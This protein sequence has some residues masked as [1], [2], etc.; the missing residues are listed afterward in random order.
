MPVHRH[1]AGDVTSNSLD[2]KRSGSAAQ[3]FLP[4]FAA[5]QT[6]RMKEIVAGFHANRDDV[7]QKK[8]AARFQPTRNRAAGRASNW[9]VWG[10]P[11]S[12]HTDYPSM[13]GNRQS[14]QIGERHCQKMQLEIKKTSQM[15]KRPEIGRDPG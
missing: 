3:G 9:V 4:R 6:K 8:K 13:R 2:F 5:Y 15:P 11:G 1:R 7:F 10:V 14:P 12:S